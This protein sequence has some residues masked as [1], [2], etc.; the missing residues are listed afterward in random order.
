[1]R[2]HSTRSTLLAAALLLGACGGL[3][4]ADRAASAPQMR[5]FLDEHHLDP[6][7]VDPE[8]VAAAHQK[9]LAI[10]AAHGVDYQRYWVGK[11]SGMIYCLVRAPS[12]Q[13]AADVHREAH[14]LVADEIREV[15]PGILP[16]APSGRRLFMDTHEMGPGLKA[17]DVAEAHKKD[18][19][20]EGAH[21][22]RFLEYWVDEAGGRIHCLVEAPEAS[23][24][25]ESHRAAHGLVPVAVQ[26][27][28][29]G[30]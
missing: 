7:G 12:A 16:A 19:A 11:D 27:V 28:V 13:A 24:V 4:D 21:G 17:A 30:R 29:A 8:G 18:L 10:E 6:S 2:L 14:G 22:V 5:L 1:M 9:D 20:V 3:R 15:Q 23:A 25:V 26:E